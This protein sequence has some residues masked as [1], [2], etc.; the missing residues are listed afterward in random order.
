MIRAMSL[1]DTEPVHWQGGQ[2]SI[3][4]DVEAPTPEELQQ[5]TRSFALNHLAMEDALTH[6]QWSRFEVYPE[7][8]F[9]VFRTLDQPEACTDETER[10][11]LFW[12]PKTDTLLTIRLQDVDYLDKT[13]REFDGLSHGSEERLIYT[14]L[15]RGSD[16]F[17]EF[18]DALQ[19]QTLTLEEAMFTERRTQD[20][21]QQIFT[22]QHLIMNVRRLV[23]NAREAVA[24]FS[25]HALLVAGSNGR[26]AAPS[27]AVEVQAQEIALYFRDVVDNLSRVHDSLDSSREV[28]SNVLNVNLSV[29]QARVNDVVKTLTVVSAIFLPLTFLAGVWGMN[30]EF[31]PEL[32]WRYGYLVAWT[33]FIGVAV[34]L[35]WYF[36]RRNWW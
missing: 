3:W 19:D 13:W 36:K 29:Q 22:Y 31:M 11:S 7:H 23:S 6:G 24:A 32:H 8:I 34:G 25:R 26:G 28:L 18:T 14:L 33:S 4:V 21:A 16:T 20:F 5:L 1:L 15:A 17:F 12:Y 30:F 10:V 27:P 9:L 2:P 35:G